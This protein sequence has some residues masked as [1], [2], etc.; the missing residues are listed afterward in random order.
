M[1]I[2]YNSRQILFNELKGDNYGIKGVP[3]DY[4]KYMLDIGAAYGLISIMARLLHPEMKIC[5]IE[6]HPETYKDLIVNCERL[7]IETIN[8]AFGNGD[9]FYLEKERKMKLCNSFASETKDTISI[10][11]Y[12]LSDLV[13]MNKYDPSDM[14]IKMDCE[15]AEWYMVGNKEDEEI[16]KKCKLM[17][18]EIHDKSKNNPIDKFYSWIIGLVGITHKITINK[19]TENLGLVKIWQGF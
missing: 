4:I 12:T 6:P 17:S 18:I 14:M 13:K 16:I 3:Q 11:S 2:N 7:K 19:L 8:C 1:K 15:S 5:A 10:Q 9:L